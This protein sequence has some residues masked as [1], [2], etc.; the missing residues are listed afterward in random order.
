[1]ITGE[2]NW[3]NAVHFIRDPNESC[4]RFETRVCVC[5]LRSCACMCV[6][7]F[8]SRTLFLVEFGFRHAVSNSS[9]QIENVK[10]HFNHIYILCCYRSL[11]YGSSVCC[12]KLICVFC[13]D[14][15]DSIQRVPVN[16]CDSL[17]EIKIY[18]AILFGIHNSTDLIHSNEKKKSEKK[19]ET[20]RK[21]TTQLNS[22]RISMKSN[23]TRLCG[24]R[25]FQFQSVHL[26][27]KWK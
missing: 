26:I 1:M 27:F 17:E 18:W 14:L 6:F 11:S 10:S 16:Y 19:K 9:I 23:L 13:S 12:W 8:K 2:C 4:T 21:H 5:P 20:L 24:I 7:F 15:F 3:I 22:N 25:T